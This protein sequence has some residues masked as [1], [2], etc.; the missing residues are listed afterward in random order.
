MEGPAKGRLDLPWCPVLDQPKHLD[1][2]ATL[3]DHPSSLW[4]L[5]HHDLRCRRPSKNAL[6]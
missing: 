1:I 6:S 2:H 3:V 5:V 4:L